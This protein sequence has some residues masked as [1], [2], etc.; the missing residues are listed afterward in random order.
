MS[1]RTRAAASGEVLSTMSNRSNYP[2]G[3]PDPRDD[4]YRADDGHAG[5]D[6]DPLVE[7]ARI[8]SEGNAKYRPVALVDPAEVDEPEAPRGS[9]D[10]RRDLI[11][12]EAWARDLE[13]GLSD[14]FGGYAP[15]PA[16]R[17][18]PA[19]D[20]GYSEEGYY[21][22]PYAYDAG[23]APQAYAEEVY[24]PRVH[25]P[26]EPAVHDPYASEPVH[27]PQAYAP[28]DP[29]EP[30][31][32]ADE[33]HDAGAD[34]ADAGHHGWA[35]GAEAYPG[36]GAPLDPVFD[37]RSVT[38]EPA[39]PADAYGQQPVAPA[40]HAEEFAAEPYAD[41]YADPYRDEARF[42]EADLGAPTR[43]P[44]EG[45]VPMQSAFGAPAGF[46]TDFDATPTRERA[47]T[48][49]L[50][51]SLEDE[52]LGAMGAGRPQAGAPVQPQ[53][54]PYQVDSRYPAQASGYAGEP[55]FEDEQLD[56]LLLEDDRL[57]ATP[58]QGSHASAYAG[59]G[60]D[61]AV[62]DIF[63][64][65]P[66]A[67]PPPGGYDLDEVAQAMREGDPQLGGHGVLPP[68]SQGGEEA[69]PEQ[70]SRRGLYAAAAV[71]GLVV[72]GGG[73]FAVMD[74]GDEASG[75]PPV[76]TS[77]GE[78]MKV[79]P[80]GQEPT[81]N[82]QSKLIYDRVGGVETPRDE[83]LV[84]QD[85]TPVASLPPA[86]DTAGTS[87]S[88]VPAGPRRVRTVV[89]R[90]DGT[91]ISSDEP[92]TA[93]P[94]TQPDAAA[95]P[96]AVTTPADLRVPGTDAAPRVVGT[97]AGQQ[98]VVPAAGQNAGQ[99]A[100]QVADAA[101]QVRTTA[102]VPD[103]G[104]ATQAPGD[105]SAATAST[106]G[107]DAPANVPRI[108]P[109]DIDTLASSAAPPPAVNRQ[110]T[111][112][113]SSPA[114]LDLTAQAGRAQNTQSAPAAPV[115]TA[116]APAASSASIPSGAYIVQ[117]SSQRTQEQAQ[118]AFNDLQRRYGSVLGGVSPVIQRADL[119]DRG[120]FYRVRIPAGSRDD[121]ISLCERLKSA[122]GD[123]FVRRN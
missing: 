24:E 60:F 87:Q 111:P 69:A 114:P 42:D 105:V 53:D 93:G 62:D 15:E 122:G 2:A 52:L 22:E 23:P 120:T 96:G 55:A 68:H 113:S 86:P 44:Y 79:Y 90:P 51:A 40:G 54:D 57:L 106:T 20:A 97:D 58:A 12:H 81:A 89:V 85:Q 11:D 1:A 56:D 31:A 73:A 33:G 47:L 8:V 65:D 50:S 67:P 59:E 82:G 103:G 123:C 70:K 46:D 6:E 4:R 45:Q 29:Y 72:L 115:Q 34:E 35:H 66:E 98:P 26:R 9:Y 5:F 118:T 78:P 48:D 83:R 3:G 28:H 38:P 75:P 10:A 76:I 95:Q 100:Q 99:T 121:A 74:F 94:E 102:I 116:S 117:V 92:V 27:T 39:L 30:A 16:Y 41:P 43:D 37:P 109:G 91:I 61:E 112:A 77:D 71:L 63:Q 110:A 18:E 108:K 119:G 21:E 101:R 17:E 36:E 88:N 25:A 7:L 13:A 84:L 19:A 32:Y 104:P 14:D 80:E 107:T 64:S 49:D